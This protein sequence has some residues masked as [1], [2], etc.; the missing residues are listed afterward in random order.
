MAAVSANGSAMATPL[1][2]SR[3]CCLIRVFHCW[4]N[5]QTGFDAA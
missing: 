1:T 3:Q 4:T 2:S 5:M